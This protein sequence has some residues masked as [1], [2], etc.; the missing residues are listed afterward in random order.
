M[1]RPNDSELQLDLEITIRGMDQRYGVQQKLPQKRSASEDIVIRIAFDSLRQFRHCLKKQP[2]GVHAESNLLF[3]LVSSPPCVVDAHS[4]LRAV[5]CELESGP[6]LGRR[7]R[8]IT[9]LRDRLNRMG[10]IPPLSAAF[11]LT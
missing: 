6:R 11:G 3:L 7:A 10:S 1:I 9:G 5:L 2:R 8:L 4:V